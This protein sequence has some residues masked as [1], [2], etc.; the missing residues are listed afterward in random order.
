MWNG[1]AAGK[2]R[3]RV[4]D[5]IRRP[6]RADLVNRRGTFS[7]PKQERHSTMMILRHP[8]RRLALFAIPAVLVAVS[9]PGTAA[10]S[11]NELRRENQALQARVTELERELQAARD[12]I[13]QLETVIEEMRKS[14]GS[15]TTR[16]PSVQ[17]EPEKVSIDESKQDASPR[18]L[19]AAMQKDMQQDLAGIEIGAEG[20][21]ER[22]NYMR[23]LDRWVTGAAREFRIPVEWHVKI[24]DRKDADRTRYLVRM[25]AVD[26]VHNTKLGDPFDAII[27][28]SRAGGVDDVTSTYVIR[29]TV[30]P[31]IRI[32]PQRAEQGTF[33]VPKLVGPYAE[34]FF[35]VEVNTIVKASEMRGTQPG[36]GAGGGG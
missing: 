9:A 17:P 4:I 5:Q 12:R 23:A 30:V 29:G 13:K 10:Q 34:F 32:N 15:S 16:P 25:Q 27:P 6:G 3:F 28:I 26:P 2:P 36:G 33:D 19:L 35:G 8:F 21:R 7:V 14:G 22:D 31:D 24:L 11:D 1:C 18:A 20:S